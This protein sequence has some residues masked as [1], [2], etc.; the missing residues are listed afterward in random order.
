MQ[1]SDF[2]IGGAQDFG[3]GSKDLTC[4]SAW[5]SRKTFE[6]WNESVH[7]SFMRTSGDPTESLSLPARCKWVMYYNWFKLIIFCLDLHTEP[8]ADCLQFKKLS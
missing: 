6:C 7:A 8:N 1:W 3:V 4:L 5:L 2:I